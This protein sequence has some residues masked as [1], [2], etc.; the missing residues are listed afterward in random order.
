MGNTDMTGGTERF[1]KDEDGA[2]SE[3]R[4]MSKC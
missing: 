1:L 3:K 2:L 4:G